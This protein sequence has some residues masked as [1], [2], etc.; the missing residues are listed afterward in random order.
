MVKSEKTDKC[1][2]CNKDI[3]QSN[4]IKV[5]SKLF[6]NDRCLSKYMNR[7]GGKKIT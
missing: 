2:G 3:D 4:C 5:E 1:M 6:H 7:P